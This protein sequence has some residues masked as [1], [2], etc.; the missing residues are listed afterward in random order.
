MC[1]LQKLFRMCHLQKP[2]TDQCC[3]KW[4]KQKQPSPVHFILHECAKMSCKATAELAEG[5]CTATVKLTK[6]QILVK[7]PPKCLQDSHT[8]W[9]TFLNTFDLNNETVS[10]WPWLHHSPTTMW[11][12]LDTLRVL[13]WNVGEQQ[14]SR[15]S[16]SKT[17]DIMY[18]KGK[19]PLGA[20]SWGKSG[21]EKQ[22]GTNF[23]MYTTECLEA[24]WNVKHKMM[25]QWYAVQQKN[26]ATVKWINI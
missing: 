18:P 15:N 25:Q 23:T 2:I 12:F 3:E 21:T 17:L 22:M 13:L 11:I 4:C 5:K 19:Q 9:N 26:K 14:S 1:H 7:N 8:C 10:K 6:H 24:G 16:S 20:M